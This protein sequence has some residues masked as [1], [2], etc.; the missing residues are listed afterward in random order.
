MQIESRPRYKLRKYNG[1]IGSFYV[2]YSC[3][4]SNRLHDFGV[5]LLNGKDDS[6]WST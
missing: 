1:I 6:L 4:I 2:D 5:V 3:L